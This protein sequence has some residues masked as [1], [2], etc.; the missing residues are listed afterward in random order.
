MISQPKIVKYR[1]FSCLRP[2]NKGLFQKHTGQD[3]GHLR[4]PPHTH[5]HTNTPPRPTQVTHT[6]H[7]PPT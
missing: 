1:C 4:T 6:T 3:S 7:T 5:T 2:K